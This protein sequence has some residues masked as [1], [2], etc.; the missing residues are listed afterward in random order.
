MDNIQMQNIEKKEPL[1]EFVLTFDKTDAINQLGLDEITIDMLLDNFFLTLDSDIN[2]IQEAIDLKDSN[3]ISQTAHYLKGSCANL[4]MK[5]AVDILQ[6]IES[7]S[8]LGET[9]F[10]LKKLKEIFEKIKQF[11]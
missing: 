1:E 9:N 11:I 7:K 6:D 8:K 10:D 4:V 5:D 2:N 3:K